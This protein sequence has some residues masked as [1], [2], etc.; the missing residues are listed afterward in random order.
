VNAYF[1]ALNPAKKI[2]AKKQKQYKIK[3]IRHRSGFIDANEKPGTRI[4]KKKPVLKWCKLFAGKSNL[5]FNLIQVV[6]RLLILFA[7]DG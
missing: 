4:F 3:I 5:F 7:L 2:K 6:K 1:A